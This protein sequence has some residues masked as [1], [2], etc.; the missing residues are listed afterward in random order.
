M[1]SDETWQPTV[2]GKKAAYMVG[3]M[4]VGE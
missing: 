2:Q 4:E 1:A 3:I